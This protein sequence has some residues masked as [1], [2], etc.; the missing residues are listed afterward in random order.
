MGFSMA[1]CLRRFGQHMPYRYRVPCY[2]LN[3]ELDRNCD[4]SS[5]NNILARFYEFLWRQFWILLGYFYY[6]RLI[7]ISREFFGSHSELEF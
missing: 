5:N 6:D 4:F 7:G 3:T 2:Q 1:V